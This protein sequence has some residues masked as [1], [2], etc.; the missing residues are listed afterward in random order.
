MH[1]FFFYMAWNACIYLREIA[2]SLHS[3]ICSLCLWSFDLVLC[4]IVFNYFVIV[5]I[6]SEFKTPYRSNSVQSPAQVE[7][8]KTFWS[9]LLNDAR[10][11]PTEGTLSLCDYL[12]LQEKVL[13]NS[14]ARRY[15]HI[16]KV[17]AFFWKSVSILVTLFYLAQGRTDGSR[18]DGVLGCF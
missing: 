7:L 1:L 10:V 8:V 13:C 4:V 3:Q 18:L 15:N 14:E 6:N 9:F 17:N 11:I 12:Q 16:P 5:R 2:I